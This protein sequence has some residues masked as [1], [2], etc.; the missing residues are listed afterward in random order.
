VQRRTFLQLIGAAAV[1]QAQPRKPNFVFLLADD[2]GWADLGCYGSTFHDTPNLD[3]FAKTGIK[4]TQAY[5]ACPVCSP[6]RA[7]IMTGKYPARIGLTDYLPGLQPKEH[8]LL[9]VEDIDALPTS[10]FTI[11]EAMKEAGYRTFMRGKWHL[12]EPGPEQHGFNDAKYIGGDGMPKARMDKRDVSIVDDAV[13][14]ID[15]NR[16]NPFFAYLA[17]T[18][19]HLPV[20][21]VDPYTPKY[22]KKLAEMKLPEQRLSKERRGNTRLY[23]D[24]AEYA[25]MIAALDALVGRVLDKL[26]A[27]KLTKNT[28]VVFT[29]DNGGLCTHGNPA[30][31]PTSNRPLR[32]GKGWCYEGGVRIPLM[33]RAPGVT[34]AGTVSGVPVIT[35]DHYPT[36]LE[37][38]GLPLRREQHRDGVSIVPA[39]KGQNSLGRDTLYWHYPHHHGS[40][41]A[42]GAAMRSGD[43]KLIEFYEEDK[44]ELY[45]LREDPGEQH[46]LAS[47]QPEKLRELRGKLAAWQKSVGAKMPQRNPAYR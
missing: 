1:A 16:D 36:M 19:P 9:S 30:G 40:S 32:S 44:A 42:P 12:G 22:E 27:L 35:T 46:D 39:L 29:S 3:R 34:K 28:V 33:V 41:W 24:N 26:E 2:L 38:A 25:A 31:G 18:Y 23:Q 10:E 21:P 15:S 14:F 47:K 7:S 13:Q 11:A 8:K 43:W 5:S 17:F 6:T 45:N 37:L 20:H 4:F